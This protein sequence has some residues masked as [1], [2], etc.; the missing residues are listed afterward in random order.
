MLTE[1]AMFIIA[2]LLVKIL[3]EIETK[4]V[5]SLYYQNNNE[6]LP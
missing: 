3:M 2:D 4:L 5:Y 1:I 6:Q